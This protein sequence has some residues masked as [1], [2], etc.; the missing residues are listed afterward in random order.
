MFPFTTPCSVMKKE[1]SLHT[2]S[3]LIC[4]A[5]ENH[6]RLRKPVSLNPRPLGPA[7]TTG[8]AHSS[9]R[10]FRDASPL[11]RVR[12]EGHSEPSGNIAGPGRAH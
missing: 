12:G 11:R 1:E 8:G 10:G 9:L 3:L 4:S 6:L 7:P 2:L 5:A